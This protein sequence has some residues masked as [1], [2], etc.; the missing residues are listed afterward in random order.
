MAEGNI[1]V[2][3]NQSSLTLLIQLAGSL[4][5]GVR[6]QI[7]GITGK[8]P[9]SWID[10]GNFYTHWD[11]GLRMSILDNQGMYYAIV[12]MRNFV[13]VLYAS[14]IG[15]PS[16]DMEKALKGS[17]FV[18]QELIEV[19]IIERRQADSSYRPPPLATISRNNKE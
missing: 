17:S 14:I 2:E 9:R 1:G 6:L 7:F 11:E 10:T 8:V 18:A 5:E 4:S 13:R 15:I 16:E 3:Q 12:R 19:N